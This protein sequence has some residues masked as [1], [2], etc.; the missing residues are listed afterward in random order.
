MKMLCK[1]TRGENIESQHIIYATALDESGKTVFNTGPKG[2]TTC[3]RSSLKPFQASASILAGATEGFSSEEIA[4]MCAS[5][6]GEK[7]HIDVAKLISNSLLILKKVA[8]RDQAT[9]L[10]IPNK[11]ANELGKKLP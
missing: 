4:L 6:N 9:P 3:A 10:S 5:H 2:Y 7:I 8:Q 11:S 1:V